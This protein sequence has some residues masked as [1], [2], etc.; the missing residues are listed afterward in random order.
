MYEQTSKLRKIVAEKNSISDI[1]GDGKNLKVYCVTSGKGGVGKTNLSVNLG[2]A[3]QSLGKKVLLIDADLG[4]ANIDVLLGLFPE[5]NLSHILSIGKSI[6]DI[7]LEGPLGISILPGASGL[8]E[9]ANISNSDIKLLIN[10]FNT[11]ADDFDII[12]IDTSAGISKNVTSFITSSNETIVITTPEP[13]ALADAYAIIKI[14]REFCDKIHVVVNK[15]DNY[16]EANRTMEK[17]S[18]SA[19]KFLNM[20]LNYLGFVLEDE[21]VH[22]ANME[23]VAFFVNYPNS[24]A[25]K[26]LMDIG[27][28]LVYGEPLLPKTNVTL[29]SWFTRLVSI[30]KANTGVI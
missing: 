15:A 11:L 23:Q 27:R 16:K 26:C 28:K 22:K 20:Q 25:S 8:Y 9:L 30:I 6:H 4:L 21:T 13:G 7:I 17:L 14:S 12:I 2:L 1:S 10:S 3:M 24:L 5:Y 18:R 19:K 29:N